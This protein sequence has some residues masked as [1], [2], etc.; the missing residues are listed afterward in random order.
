M[1]RFRCG[2]LVL[3]F[4]L[5]VCLGALPTW[6]AWQAMNGGNPIDTGQANNFLYT[7]TAPY[8]AMPT[9]HVS[10]GGANGAYDLVYVFR[11]GTETFAGKL[12]SDDGDLVPNAAWKIW[13]FAGWDG[14]ADIVPAP[15]DNSMWIDRKVD[16]ASHPGETGRF[17]GVAASFKKTGGGG[18]DEHGFNYHF[19][20]SESA[21]TKRWYDGQ[22]VAFGGQ[23]ILP[24]WGGMWG[25]PGA[26][27]FAC[28]S[29]DY[30][31]QGTGLLVTQYVPGWDESHLYKRHLTAA[32]L[33][34]ASQDAWQWQ[35]WSPTGWS[36]VPAPEYIPAQAPE[37][38][39]HFNPVVKHIPGSQDFLVS[40]QHA[41]YWG[42]ESGQPPTEPWGLSAILYSGTPGEGRWLSWNGVEWQEDAPA[43]VD[44]YVAFDSV[45]GAQPAAFIYR[46]T[47]GKSDGTVH[48]FY[49]KPNVT[50]AT[51]YRLIYNHTAEQ[52]SAPMAVTNVA[53]PS[54]MPLEGAAFVVGMNGDD[55][56]WIAYQTDART[57]H[58]IKEAGAGWTDPVQIC[59]SGVGDADVLVRA[60]DFAGNN[61]VPVLFFIRQVPD[62]SYRLYALSDPAAYSTFWSTEVPVNRLAPTVPPM[63]DSSTYVVAELP[64]GALGH[65]YLDQESWLLASDGAACVNIYSPA[66]RKPGDLRYLWG[67]EPQGFAAYDTVVWFC[68]SIVGD[69]TDGRLSQP[70]FMYQ[71][72]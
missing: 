11:S 10:N 41:L 55:Q 7:Y 13:T 49:A 6:A 1:N 61:N 39:G 36:G 66:Y 45:A 3:T 27:G 25:G 71:P 42:A 47:I 24:S 44:D 19:T 48:T 4:L 22:T 35:Y 72:L 51:I 57:I 54:A 8:M 40:F 52:W 28:A 32:R 70:R 33:V 67:R 69:D 60:L 5:S 50:N 37:Q 21:G 58:L 46:P 64:V 26:L 53:L 38:F 34:H 15:L 20:F 68:T 17:F 63:P 30:D 16:L 29:F 43:S 12:T 65:I 18:L 23:P 14:S 59:P 62:M 56:I 2:T 31:G 9:V